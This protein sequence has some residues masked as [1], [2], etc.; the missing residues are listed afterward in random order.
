MNNFLCASKTFLKRNGATILTYVGA[1]GVVATAV[2]AVKATPKAMTL[3]EE[4]KKEKG[5]DLTKLEKV[6]VAG[7]AYIPAVVTGTATVAC[8]FGINVL[9]KRQQAGLASAY[10][11]LDNSYKEY[12]KKVEELYGEEANQKVTEEIAKDKYEDVDIQLDDGKW[13]FYDE[14]SGRY[15]EARPEVVQAAEY[16]LNRELVMRGWVTLNEFYGSLDIEPIDGG[17]ELGWTIESNL[18][19]Y[20]QEW[21]DFGH[22]KVTM[23]DGLECTIISMFLEPTPDYA[24]YM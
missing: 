3:L 11:L 10:A 20:W 7:P 15:F 8:I 18:D 24:E 6:K 16:D 1:A 9:N 22:H 13:L 12:K 2:M 21:I 19:Y 14:F 17:D 5:E 23:D 4:A